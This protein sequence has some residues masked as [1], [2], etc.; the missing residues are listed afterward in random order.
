MKENLC[1]MR[2]DNKEQIL[3]YLVFGKNTFYFVQCIQRRKENPFL[4]KDSY[5]RGYWFITSLR[6]FEIHLERMR[7]MAEH[8]N[9][10]VYISMCPRSLEKLTKHCIVEMGKRVISENYSL[11]FSIPQ[12]LALSKDVLEKGIRPK[13]IWIVDIDSKEENYRNN[14]I[15]YLKEIDVEILG[16]LDTL[17]GY[18]LLVNAFNIGLLKTLRVTIKRNDY[19]LNSGE[20][21]TILPEG[22][23]VLFVN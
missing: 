13:P 12:K 10:R 8:F 1:D 21:F 11:S 9:A 19:K 18:H 16:T 17:N 7:S 2:I 4:E 3:P 6:E 5:Q 22:N 20:V 15:K 14:I 23:T